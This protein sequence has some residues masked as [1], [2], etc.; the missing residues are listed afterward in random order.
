VFD[1]DLFIFASCLDPNFSL[2][3]MNP[4]DKV[5]VKCKFNA[6]L[7]ANVIISKASAQPLWFSAPSQD[8]L[9]GEDDTVRKEINCYWSLA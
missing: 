8:S 9:D 3:W 5:V 7:S 2:H 1:N 4:H 6:F